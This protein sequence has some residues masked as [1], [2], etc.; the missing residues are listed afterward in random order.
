MNLYFVE[1]LSSVVQ[2]HRVDTH[3]SYSEN[4]SYIGDFIHLL[5]TSTSSPIFSAEII[6]KSMEY[7]FKCYNFFRM[8]KNE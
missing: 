2:N 8:G 3:F 5:C 1:I 6:E 4:L 7:P